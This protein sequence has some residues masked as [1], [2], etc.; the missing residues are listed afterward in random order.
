MSLIQNP[1]YNPAIP[2]SQQYIFSDPNTAVINT[3]TG[4]TAAQA[5]NNLIPT[6]NPQ[7]QVTQSQPSGKSIL[8]QNSTPFNGGYQTIVEYSD[9]SRDQK[10]SATNPNAIASPTTSSPTNTLAAGGQ[11][12]VD[13][14]TEKLS[15]YLDK[16]LSLQNVMQSSGAD[17]TAL[18]DLDKQ[19]T[20]TQR[21]LNEL[22][23]QKFLSTEPGLQNI[24]IGEDA[25]NR[26][27]IQAQEPIART[28]SDLL[29]S[30]SRLGQI[31][32]QQQQAQ[33]NQFQNMSQGLSVYSALRELTQP[34]VLA[35]NFNDASGTYTQLLEG[36]GGQVTTRNIQS[37]EIAPGLTPYEYEQVTSLAVKN[38]NAGIKVGGQ[39]GQGDNL[40][41]AINKVAAT[42]GAG[43]KL[44]TQVIELPDGTKALINSQTGGI[45]Q[46][47]S[48]SGGGS[49]APIA[50]ASGET[51]TP[52][53]KL[54]G[55]SK[56]KVENTMGARPLIDQAEELYN[57]A[58][59]STGAS[60]GIFARISGYVTGKA[61]Q[62]GLSEDWQIYKN[63]LD[64]NKAIIAR[65]MKGQTGT[66]NE[67][68]QLDAIKTFPNESS[69]PKE[70]SAAFVNVRRQTSDVLKTYGT[71]IIPNTQPAPSQGIQSILGSNLLGSGKTSS[72]MGFKIIQ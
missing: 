70:A 45:I 22:T 17:A 25:L 19:V 35:T 5:S 48:S 56:T 1:N 49:A 14:M 13:P 52:T 28:L 36:P 27:T 7:P 9:G 37:P 54:E 57:K 11:Q 38:P 67:Q 40:Q 21:T 42:P 8:S 33:Q 10:W 2:G 66:L 46:R 31:Q 53:R 71:L 34:K 60:Q 15:T 58:V 12:P 3:V 16:L 51:F 32:Q 63:F 72:G 47:F 44:D 29:L 18:A 68:E 65:G 61:A 6:T 20:D 50:N 62:A 69:T 39:P 4:Q 59:A 30:R 41:T 55:D 64:S 26:R 23:P 24:G 43:T